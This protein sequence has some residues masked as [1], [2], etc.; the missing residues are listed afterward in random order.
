MGKAGNREMTRPRG[1]IGATLAV[2][3]LAKRRLAPPSEDA[4]RELPQ[5]RLTT[6]VKH[7]FT[8][9]TEKIILGLPVRG[10]HYATTDLNRSVI[11]GAAIGIKRSRHQMTP[12]EHLGL[13]TQFADSLSHQ[14]PHPQFLN[15][16]SLSTIVRFLSR[17][18]PRLEQEMGLGTPL[19]CDGEG[20]KFLYF[21]SGQMGPNGKLPPVER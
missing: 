10:Q 19:R 13:K 20:S 7:T 1:C 5:P 6:L 8:A 9:F 2:R 14:Y 3:L 17:A 4:S 11:P 18:N 12:R 21:S 16:C 15:W